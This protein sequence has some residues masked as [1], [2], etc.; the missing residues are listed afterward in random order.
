MSDKLQKQAGQS[1]HFDDTKLGFK[2]SVHPV[3]GVS[4]MQ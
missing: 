2:Q 4:S 3:E 1:C